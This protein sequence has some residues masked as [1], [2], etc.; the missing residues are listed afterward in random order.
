MLYDKLRHDLHVHKT[1]YRPL[2]D[3]RILGRCVER[4]A[5]GKMLDMGSGTG[6]QGIIGALKGCHVT[7]ADINPNAVECARENAMLNK[8]HGTFVVSDLFSR[9]REKFNTISFDPPYL[10]S[11]PLSTAR[12][13][14]ATDGGRGG[15]EVIERFLK[16]YKRYV[17]KRHVVLMVESYWNGY[18]HDID[19]LGAIVVDRIHYPLLGDCVVL[20]FQ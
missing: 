18:E 17:M 9:I 7:F 4:Y 15:R 12:V 20:K 16:E 8:A 1:V 14:P 6:I 10:R 3:A 11:G 2:G 19:E 13:N 5:F